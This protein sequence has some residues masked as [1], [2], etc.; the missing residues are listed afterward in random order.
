ME[1]ENV[2]MSYNLLLFK[3]S[4]T[5]IVNILEQESK[6]YVNLFQEKPK[7]KITNNYKLHQEF[8]MTCK[9]IN[10]TMNDSNTDF[11]TISK[12][13]KKVY[14]TLTKNMSL[15]YPNLDTLIFA[16]EIIPNLNMTLV[17]PL[18]K[19]TALNQFLMNMYI[20]YMSSS[21]LIAFGNET[22]TL[23]KELLLNMKK[24]LQKL[25][26]EKFIF[27]PFIGFELDSEPNEFNVNTMYE[28]IELPNANDPNMA[29]D[30]IKQL[31]FDKI[32]DMGKLKEQLNMIKDSDIENVTNSVTE[33][34]GATNDTNA[35]NMCSELITSIVSELKNSNSDEI[36]F[37]EIANKVTQNIMKNDSK[38]NQMEKTAQYFKNTLD[39]NMSQ[40][41]QNNKNPN[42]DIF[43]M[44]AQMAKMMNMEQKPEPTPYEPS[45]D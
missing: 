18:L 42:M 12:I 39:K 30:M 43:A 16:N 8:Q 28:N 7:F 17:I 2:S 25:S 34:V 23:D 19:D 44:A 3:K 14:K 45:M 29:N 32:L 20:M 24:D 11:V 33:L 41:T 40:H 36:N 5:S 21:K 31:G 35:K 1:S 37:F 10:N 38:N 27:N 9:S 6:N 26:N 15:F 4:F 13:I 22:I